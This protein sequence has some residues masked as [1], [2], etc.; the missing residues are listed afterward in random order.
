MDLEMILVSIVLFSH[1][2]ILVVIVVAMYR[3]S[4]TLED[5][6]IEYMKLRAN[7]NKYAQGIRLTMPKVKCNPLIPK[8]PKAELDFSIF[9]IEEEL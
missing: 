4:N 1:S 6:R 7:L 8:E 9:D 2:L 3:H 5:S